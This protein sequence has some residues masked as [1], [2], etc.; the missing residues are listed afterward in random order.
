MM[1]DLLAYDMMRQIGVRAPRVS[2]CRLFIDNEYFGVYKII[3]QIDKT[4][5]DENFASGE[6]NLYKNQRWSNLNWW[7]DDPNLYKDTFELK[8]NETEDDWSGFINFL[9]VLNNTPENEFAEAISEVFNVDQYLK[10]LA[11]DIMTNNWD[12]YIDNR[13]NW[14]LYH[15]PESNKFHWIPWD[16]NLSWGGRII[17]QGNPY[18]PYD[19]E[20][21]VKSDFFFAIDE[22]DV[23]FFPKSDQSAT[24]WLWEFGDGS[25][26]TEENPVHTYTSENIINKV[27]LTTFREES[28]QTC[29]QKR[30]K[31]IPMDNAASAC[32]T[33]QTGDAPYEPSDPA[34][35]GVINEDDYCCNTDWDVF[36]S[37]KYQDVQNQMNDP[38]ETFTDYTTDYE[39]LLDNPEKN[40]H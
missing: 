14:Y 30:C 29:A 25:M 8:T 6:G 23:H 39:L 34:F 18:P 9:D 36:C 27:C 26:S 40:S 4:F 3:E 22:S 13:R 1:R 33:L 21:P 7:G 15:E 17:L 12:S 24:G 2:F 31:I 37:I 5:L 10:V 20:C 11:I 38:I 32:L 19:P 16:Y 28:N 35:Q